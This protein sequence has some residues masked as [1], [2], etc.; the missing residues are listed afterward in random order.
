LHLDFKRP[1]SRQP[2]PDVREPLLNLNQLHAYFIETQFP[3]AR[4]SAKSYKERKAASGQTLT[5]LGK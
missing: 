2:A 1:I 3:I 4:L 5:K